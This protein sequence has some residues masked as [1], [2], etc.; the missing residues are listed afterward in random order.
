MLVK[1]EVDNIEEWIVHHLGI[2]F[3][4]LFIYDNCSDDGTSEL[5]QRLQKQLPIDH[6]IWPTTEGGQ[7]QF[8]AYRDCLERTRE[9]YDWVLFIDSD[10]FLIPYGSNTLAE[11]L[12]ARSG[13]GAIAINW[14]IF[15]SS[16]LDSL[17]GKL[18]MEALT[19]RAPIHF[20]PNRHVK[21]F[22]RPKE[23][24]DVINPHVFATKRPYVD[25]Q[26]R[27]L[28]WSTPGLVERVR[29]VDGP[30]GGLHHY[31]VRTEEH[32][33]RRLKR[34][35]ANRTTRAAD[36]FARYDRNDE[37]DLSAL[38]HA[39]GVKRRINQM[40]ENV[41]SSKAYWKNRFGSGGDSGMGSAGRLARMK[42]DFINA[43]LKLNN[44][45]SVVELGCG[46]GAQL[47]L[48]EFPKYLG[49][50]VSESAINACRDILSGN[51]NYQFVLDTDLMDAYECEL[52]L[53]VDVIFHLVEDEVF[54]KY[55]RDLFF[56]A[57]KYVII[58]SSDYDKEWNARHVRHRN[59]SNVVA[60]RF[61]EWRRV[62]IAPNPYPFERSQA[63]ITSFADFHVYARGDLTATIYFPGGAAE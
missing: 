41:F 62:A 13:D 59:F 48:Y 53:S 5:I 11:L 45:Q 26:G 21:S 43:F 6:Y 9:S 44:I 19:K 54:E 31:F 51:P 46:N 60:T 28:A 52:G 20:E 49:I 17:N 15:G 36:L 7:T 29:I 12:E 2:G 32:W 24:M 42:A 30:W 47:K 25:I 16:G 39:M 35:Q 1:N 38:P 3:D 57:T 33:E 8:S 22:V 63:G 27:E 56:F 18:V 14:K 58:Y 23:T 10:E 61:P 37:I 40:N 55:L 50:D 4:R 34:G